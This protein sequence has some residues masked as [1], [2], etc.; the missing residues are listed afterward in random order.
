MV[1]RVIE[2][3]IK[4]EAKKVESNNLTKST[5]GKP[6]IVIAISEKLLIL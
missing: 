5:R 6:N 4:K 1:G 2:R 3:A